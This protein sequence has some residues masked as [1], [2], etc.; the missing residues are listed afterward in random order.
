MPDADDL[1]E[2]VTL[3]I[4]Q[5]QADQIGVEIFARLEFDLARDGKEFAIGQL[6]YRFRNGV[7]VESDQQLVVVFATGDTPYRTRVCC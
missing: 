5:P 6:P 2:H 1:A 7:P 4:D 3:P